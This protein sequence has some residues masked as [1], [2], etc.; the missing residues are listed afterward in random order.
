LTN[1]SGDYLD[2]IKIFF[3]F[4]EE[5][6]FSFSVFFAFLLAYRGELVGESY[7]GDKIKE[8]LPNKRF[9]LLYKASMYVYRRLGYEFYAWV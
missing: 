4:E 2:K 7:F 6:F 1:V 9:Q 3:I 8:W 5:Y